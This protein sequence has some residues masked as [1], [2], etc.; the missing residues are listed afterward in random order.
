MSWTR[1]KLCIIVA[2]SAVIFCA[3]PSQHCMLALKER[4]RSPECRVDSF[5]VSLLYSF[6]K[7]AEAKRIQCMRN[8]SIT[9]LTLVCEIFSP[10]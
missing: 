1:A 5:L 8:K 4:I 7:V 6:W 3:G 9:G 10:L 2:S